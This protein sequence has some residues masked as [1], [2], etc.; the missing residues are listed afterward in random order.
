MIRNSI[1]TAVRGCEFS[2]NNQNGMSFGANTGKIRLIDNYIHHNNNNGIWLGSGGPALYTCKDILIRGCRVIEQGSSQSHPDNI[3]FHQ[4]CD[5]VMEDNFLQQQGH[6]NMWCEQSGRITIRNNVF[7]GG[8]IGFCQMSPAYIYNNVFDHSGLRFDAHMGTVG[9][10]VI[11]QKDVYAGGWEKFRQEICGDVSKYPFNILWDES[12]DVVKEI[13]SLP[14]NRKGLSSSLREK[15]VARINEVVDD[16]SFYGKH[17]FIYAKLSDEGAA[18]HIIDAVIKRGIMN[19]KGEVVTSHKELLK[20]EIVGLNRAV[21]DE[22][23]LDGKVRKSVHNYRHHLVNIQNNIIIESSVAAPPKELYLSPYFTVDHNYYSIENS[24]LFSS[25]GKL[26]G[27]G[28]G[29]II[30]RNNAVVPNEFIDYDEGDFHL[31]AGSQLIDAGADVGLP[32]NSAAP[33]IGCYE[34]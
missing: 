5:L 2:H 28:R 15:I 17:S 32:Y 13:R 10:N 25:W 4:I 18:R 21:L 22:I 34:F 19:E 6:Q 23:L 1:V 16:F 20:E 3:Q 12:F 33:D 27:F 11:A 24:W 31:K 14:E 30:G 9:A 29:S 8:R 26:V 7:R